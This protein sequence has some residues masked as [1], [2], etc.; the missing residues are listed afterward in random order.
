MELGAC[1]R[2]TQH[3]RKSAVRNLQVI[4]CRE[5]PHHTIPRHDRNLAHPGGGDQITVARVF[6]SCRRDHSRSLYSYS[7]P[8]R[9]DLR[10]CC[11]DSGRKPASRRIGPK[12]RWVLVSR[13]SRR[14]R[15]FPCGNGRNVEGPGL[16]IFANRYQRFIGKR[17]R[18]AYQPVE[19]MCVEQDARQGSALGRM[20]WGGR[21]WALGTALDGLLRDRFGQVNALLDRELATLQRPRATDGHVF[22]R[23]RVAD[24]HGG[25]CACLGHA[26]NIANLV[27]LD[28]GLVPSFSKMP[29]LDDVTTECLFLLRTRKHHQVSVGIA[30]GNLHLADCTPGATRRWVVRSVFMRRLRFADGN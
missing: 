2:P 12:V 7:L 17:F 10:R 19:N 24:C 8:D 5:P 6:V 27:C 21:F 4:R 3:K 26:P 1:R 25:C 15:Q 18:F 22:S 16:L 11:L 23:L 29:I 14:D 30:I 28:E 9:N 20:F 13:L